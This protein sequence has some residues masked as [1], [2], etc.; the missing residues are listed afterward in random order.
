MRLSEA[1]RLGSLLKPQGFGGGSADMSAMKTC[2]YGAANEA[3]GANVIPLH[4][5]PWLGQPGICPSCGGGGREMLLGIISVH[6]NDLHR[7]TREQIADWVET[8]EPKSP[9]AAPVE[10]PEL[11]SQ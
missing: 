7:W 4:V 11:I 10:I 9:E 6:L 2:A 3:L 8:V 1:I 5:W